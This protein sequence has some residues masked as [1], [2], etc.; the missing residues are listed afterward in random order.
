MRDE[1]GSRAPGRNIR[2]HG[3]R[4]RHRARSAT[5]REVARSIRQLRLL[6]VPLLAPAP[7]ALAPAGAMTARAPAGGTLAAIR[8][9]ESG[10]NYAAVSRGGTYRGA[11][12]FDRATWAEVGGSGDPAAATPAE[13]DLRAALLY[14]RAGPGRWPVCGR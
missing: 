14:Q 4:I 3:V 2:R 11:Y 7:P 13:Q 1:L 9:C 5:A 8:A 12:Q 6:R 10:G